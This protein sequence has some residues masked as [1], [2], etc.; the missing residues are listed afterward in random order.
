MVA[1]TVPNLSALEPGPEVGQVFALVEQNAIGLV[2]APCRAAHLYKQ[3]IRGT[4]AEGET[5]A[6]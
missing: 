5:E 2:P 4:A 1:R 3:T 6:L